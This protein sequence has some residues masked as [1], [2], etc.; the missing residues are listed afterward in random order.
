MLHHVSIG[1]AGV[2]RAAEFYDAVLGALG[3]KRTAQYLPYAIA[4]GE[5]VSE[6]WIQLPH[7]NNPASA[8]NGVHFGFAAG[9][10]DAIHRFHET[11]L[12]NG[13]K[14]DGSPGP[15]PQYG[16]DYYGAFVVDPFG[17][18]IE[19]T[20]IAG[21]ARSR[22]RRAGGAKRTRKA[23]AKRT[24]KAAAKRGAARKVKA[25]RGG[26]ARKRNARRR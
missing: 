23:G 4:Y 25:K 2:E 22:G 21:E 8:G 24:R 10:Q 1:V 12:A 11:A 5:G 3:Y 16:P 15:R 6:F 14:D 9:S 18:K 7:D 19:A 20:F 13:G 17:N 26:G